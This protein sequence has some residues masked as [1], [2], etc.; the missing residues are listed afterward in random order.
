MTV[1]VEGYYRIIVCELMRNGSLYDHIFGLGGKKLS[2]SARKKIA[3]GMA[4]GLAYLH[5]RIR[6][7]VKA[8]NILI[9]ESFKP[10][11]TDFGLAKFTQEG[12]S[13]LSTKVAGTL[14]YVA[15]EYGLYG[16]LSER[17]DVYSYGV[18]LIIIIIIILVLVHIVCKHACI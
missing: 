7:E 1:P 10:K 16:Q 2:W 9:D 8:S 14:G 15:P 3:L 13:Y 4:R 12:R 17:S 18:V 11:L 6:R 5:Y